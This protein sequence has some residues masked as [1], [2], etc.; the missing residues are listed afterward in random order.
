M[1]RATE[2]LKQALPASHMRLFWRQRHHAMLPNHVDGSTRGSPAC[3]EP[4]LIFI[5]QSL[6]LSIAGLKINADTLEGG[7]IFVVLVMLTQRK[8]HGLIMGLIVK[9]AN[10]LADRNAGVSLKLVESS[11]LRQLNIELRL[12]ISLSGHCANVSET[13]RPLADCTTILGGACERCESTEVTLKAWPIE[14]E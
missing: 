6:H 9:V 13:Q 14:V 8:H 2:V 7:G 11:R 1:F 4:A 12:Q 3:V 10:D 5:K